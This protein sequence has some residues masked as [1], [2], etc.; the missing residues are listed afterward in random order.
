VEAQP[1]GY[2]VD[3]Q[4]VQAHLGLMQGVIQR[5]ASN[6]SS[7]KT[8][9]VTLVSAILVTV[10]DR[11]KTEYAVIGAIPILLF[12][13]LDT[14][15]LSLEKRFRDSY[16]RFIDKLHLG[17]LVAA[18]LYAITPTGSPFRAAVASMQ[19]LSVWPFYVAL[20]VLAA[21]TKLVLQAG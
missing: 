5:M 12:F 20:L 3:S 11:N 4:A 13:A 18:D 17:N 10:A 15:Y 16:N 6:S 2:A 7:C 14:Y 1:T 21:V 9:C 19:S 8:W